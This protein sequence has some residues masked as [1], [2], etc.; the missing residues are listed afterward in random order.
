MRLTRNTTTNTSATAAL[1]AGL[2]CVEFGY[3]YGYVG[4]RLTTRGRAAVAEF[5]VANQAAL[6]VIKRH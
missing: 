2:E 3:R 4:T 1:L 5:L 6:R